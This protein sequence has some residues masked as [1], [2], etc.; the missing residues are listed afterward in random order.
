MKWWQLKKRRADLERELHSDLELEEEEQRESGL[1]REEARFAARR[2]FGNTTLIKEQTHEAWGW[3]PMER[4]LRDLR[5]AW[6]VLLKSPIFAATAIITLAL[7]IGANTAIF[8]VMNAV[9][10]RMLPVR[11][12]QQLYYLTHQHEPPTVSTTGDS[13]Y[14]FGIN[15]YERLRQDQTVFC[16]LIA[17]EPLAQGKTAVRFG[18]APE[19]IEADEVSGN[20]FSAV[21]LHSNHGK[22]L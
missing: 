17:Y 18:D 8:S 21:T 10:L 3:A 13:R 11:E 4:F 20:F 9:L 1:S 19:E 22:C 5:L 7:G 16:E 15:V 2:A 6:R 12:P 14:T